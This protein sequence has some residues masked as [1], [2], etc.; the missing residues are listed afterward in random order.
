MKC[1]VVQDLLPSYA[2]GLTS[3]ESNREIEKHLKTCEKCSK[4]YREMTGEV[5]EILP[6]ADVTD[7]ALIVGMRKKRKKVLIAAAFAVIILAAALVWTF[8]GYS[9][10]SRNVL[11][12]DVKLSYGLKENGAYLELTPKGGELEFNGMTENIEDS[13][14]NIIGTRTY[15]KALR[16]R[17]GLFVKGSMGWENEMAGDAYICEWVL[18][19]SDKTITIRN[20]KL[21]SEE[22]ISSSEQ[23]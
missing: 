3:E 9:M 22:N 19:F 11:S 4:Y 7:A 23:N 5:P 16:F 15:L 18:E 6:K 20:G 12:S 1:D 2:D 13:S 10:G 14:G 17:K 8:T 21:I